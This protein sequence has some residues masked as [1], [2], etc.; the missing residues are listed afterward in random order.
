MFKKIVTGIMIIISIVSAIIIA[1]IS[2]VPNWWE[3]SEP[4]VIL[5]FSSILFTLIVNN[6]DLIR[7]YTYPARVCFLAWAYGH[8]IFRTELGKQSYSVYKKHQNS[9]AELFEVTQCLY[10]MVAL[11]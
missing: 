7:R 9:Y 3:L 2:D 11:R 6:G 5:F 8:K 1:G 10:D 4:W